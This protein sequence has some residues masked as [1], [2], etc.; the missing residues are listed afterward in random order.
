MTK[1]AGRQNK[2]MTKQTAEKKDGQVGRL[3]D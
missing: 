1:Q 3:A 2:Q